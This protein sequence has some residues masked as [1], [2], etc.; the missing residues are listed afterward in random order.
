MVGR[1][2]AEVETWWVD[3]DFPTDKLSI[4]ERLKAVARGMGR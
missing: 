4:I 2:L 3:N 1:V